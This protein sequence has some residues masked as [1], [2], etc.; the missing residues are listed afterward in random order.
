VTIKTKNFPAGKTFTVRMGVI[1][2]RAIG[3]E[4]VGTQD[5]GTGGAFE[6]TFNIPTSLKGS[7]RIAIRMDSTTGGFFAFNWFFNNTATGP[8][9]PTVTSTVKTA[10]PGGPT[11]SPT[12]KTATPGGP[13]ATPSSANIPTFSITAVVKDTSVTIKTNNLPK[14]QTFTVRMGAIGT[15]AIGGTVVGT[16]D[17]GAGG[18]L[19]ATYNIP[20][21][22]QGSAQIA[23]R[24]DSPAGFFAFNWFFNVTD[25]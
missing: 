22:L 19:T 12:S 25:P 1:G 8:G 5:S 7:S 4:V 17:S 2:T 20:A 23:I 16:L 13:T 9:T 21:T 15:R 11:T 18:V 14:N 24:M 6:A 3:G 10:T